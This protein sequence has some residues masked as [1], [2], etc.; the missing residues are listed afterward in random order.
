MSELLAR[1]PH[2]SRPGTAPVEPD[3]ARRVP[4]D[5]VRQA[6]SPA[7]GVGM[8]YPAHGRKCASNPIYRTSAMDYGVAPPGKHHFQDQYCPRGG[9]FTGGFT[10]LVPRNMSLNTAV[11]RSKV[12]KKLESAF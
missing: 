11:A 2:V 3:K 12:H 4:S 10:D 8:V 9:K 7:K 5:D 1:R 6:S